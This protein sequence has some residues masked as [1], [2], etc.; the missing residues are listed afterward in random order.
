MGVRE[1]VC[2]NNGLKLETFISSQRMSIPKI[3]STFNGKSNVE[4]NLIHFHGTRCTSKKGGILEPNVR[5]KK[6][7]ILFK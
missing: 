1:V 6:L 2:S 3:S 5:N 4:T 7:E